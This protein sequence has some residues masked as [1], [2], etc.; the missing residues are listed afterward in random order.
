MEGMLRVRPEVDTAVSSSDDV[1]GSSPQRQLPGVHPAHFGVFKVGAYP[2]PD[3]NH[4][5]SLLA[6]RPPF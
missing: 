4:L 1:T 5:R 6:P 3:S 2:D